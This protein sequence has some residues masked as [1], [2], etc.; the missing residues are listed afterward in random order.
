MQNTQQ[1][2]HPG[3]SDQTE[4][5]SDCFA[6]NNEIPEPVQVATVGQIETGGLPPPPPRPKRWVPQRKAEIVA[7]VR[8]GYLTFDDACERYALSVE[9]F[10]T[11]QHGIDVFGLAGLRINHVQVYRRRRTRSTK[12]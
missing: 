3:N 2:M 1:E 4:P 8:D 6:N 7:A 9:E 10:L 12:R 5:T 11:W